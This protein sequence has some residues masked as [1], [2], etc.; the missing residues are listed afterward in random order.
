ML[1]NLQWFNE[2]KKW[3][4]LS[5]SSLSMF[6]TPQTDF[7]RETHYGF[8]VDDGPFYYAKVGGEFEMEVKIIGDYRSR[9]DQMGLMIR[10][11][12]KC[13]IKTGIEYVDEKMN[14]SAVVTRD[15]SDWSVIELDH[16][17]E[18]VWLKLI[19]R[20]NAG[21]IQ[22][23]LDKKTYKMMRL[24][25]FP[26]KV[27]VEIGLNAASPDGDGFTALFEEFKIQ[28]LPDLR[29]KK[30]LKENKEI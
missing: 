29:R 14:L 19:R 6:V 26:D 23:S 2:P 13:W 3:K 11:D 25:Y 16:K 20:L 10:K 4:I 8:T 15:F 1:N 17:P 27:A 18:A 9:Y 30:W 5:E 28:H 12:E 7:W 21:E 24:A 22:Y